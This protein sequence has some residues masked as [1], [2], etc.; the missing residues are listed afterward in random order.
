[1]QVVQLL[2]STDGVHIRIDA[3]AWLYLV[4]GQRQALPF[5][6][7]VNDLSTSIAQVLDGERHCTLHTI[8]VVVDAQS[9][10]YEEW[11]R[12][13]T[14]TQLGR[15]VLL[16]ELLNHLNTLL[17]LLSTEQGLVVD[18]FDQLTHLIFDY[19]TIYYFTIYYFTIC[20]CKG[21]NFILT[22]KQKAKLFCKMKE[23][24]DY[25]LSLCTL[26][27]CLK[28]YNSQFSIFNSQ[29]KCV[30]LSNFYKGTHFLGPVA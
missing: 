18:W 15:Q 1:M 2:V 16:K 17:C 27:Q 8:Q 5:S 19:L 20:D 3:I 24:V 12:H 23:K 7:R 25:S 11:S 26:Q 30:P 28:E 9:L 29:L 4:F 21:T 6:Q 10:Q 14:Q 13:T 22:S